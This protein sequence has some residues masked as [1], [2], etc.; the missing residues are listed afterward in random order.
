MASLAQQQDLLWY[1][2]WDI[3]KEHAMLQLLANEKDETIAKLR[4]EKDE[5]IAKLRRDLVNANNKIAKLEHMID[6]MTFLSSR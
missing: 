4:R 2:Y 3:R 6:P 1:K 5:T